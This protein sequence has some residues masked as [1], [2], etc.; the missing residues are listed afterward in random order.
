VV[1]AGH[2]PLAD[3]TLLTSGLDEMVSRNPVTGFAAGV[4]GGPA[5]RAPE[6]RSRVTRTGPMAAETRL[7]R[8]A[9]AYRR[10]LKARPDLLDA[11]LRLG[12]ALAL[13]GESKAAAQELQAVATAAGGDTAYLA[14]LFLGDL[15]EQQGD[16]A[17]AV[18]AYRA[19][20]AARPASRVA[21][22]A[23]ARA[24]HASGDRAASQ[25]AVEELLLQPGADA[26]ADPWW[27]YRLRPLGRWADAIATGAR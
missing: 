7:R 10:A 27:Q 3:D 21:R 8:A 4:P 13:V 22:L 17:G 12:R 6:F 23:L 24:L 20:V 15:A 11:R 19:A 2:R 16:T 9:D 25:A 18:T 5:G 14:Q 26:G 1:D